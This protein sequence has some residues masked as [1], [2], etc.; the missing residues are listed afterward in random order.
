MRQKE[1][2]ALCAQGS[3]EEI[4]AAI[5]SG[6]KVNKKARIYNTSVPPIF[7][8]VMEE[9]LEAVEI[10]LEYGANAAEAFTAAIAKGK[11]KIL[12]FLVNCGADINQPGSK[13]LKPIIMAVTADN[14]KV[15]KWLIEL[16]A[17]VNVKTATGYNALAYVALMQ[18]DNPRKRPR[19]SNKIIK[20]LMKSGIEYDEAMIIAVKSGNIDFVETLLKNGAD[21]NHKCVVGED[22]YS[23]S[24]LGA[25]MFMGDKGISIEMIEFLAEN[26]AYPNEVFELGDQ[27]VTTPLNIAIAMDRVDVAEK[28]LIY[29]ADPDYRDPTGRTSLIYAALTSFEMFSL[30]LKMGADPNIPDENGRTPLMLAALDIGYLP[31]AI[32][33][34]VGWGADVN[35]QDI[36]GMTALLWTIATRDRTPSFFISGLIR[37]GGMMAEGAD[38]WFFIAALYAALKRDAQLSAVKFLVEHGADIHITDK[39]GM[40][41]VMCAMIN[42]DDEILEILGNA[43]TQIQ[44]SAS[45]RERA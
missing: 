32:E 8:A 34:L 36:D 25:A 30:L 33:E 45:D 38:T 7:V 24:P 42:D 2:L 21:V 10:L 39:R 43:Q 3:R 4:E 17:D 14:P 6:A 41:A 26:D 13:I 9:N 11:R 40:N 18:A 31:D 22:K 5:K 37:T 44:D 29:G 16:G 35:V 15:V 12:D 27:T 23:V 19:N 20:L 28:L 1:F